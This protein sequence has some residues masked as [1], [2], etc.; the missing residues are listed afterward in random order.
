[1]GM[2]LWVI[3][4]VGFCC[5]FYAIWESI[6]LGDEPEPAQ[7]LR[8]IIGTALWPVVVGLI[9]LLVVVCALLAIL[10]MIVGIWI[11]MMS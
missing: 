1:M 4:M 7:V 6:K 5:G 8:W 2:T 3:Y 9:V 10:D 11:W